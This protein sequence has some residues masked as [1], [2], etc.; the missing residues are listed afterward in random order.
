MR[1]TALAS[2]MAKHL[3]RAFYCLWSQIME[4]SKVLVRYH[5][6]APWEQKGGSPLV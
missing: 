2:A 1:H 6:H 3:D 5:Y 4:V